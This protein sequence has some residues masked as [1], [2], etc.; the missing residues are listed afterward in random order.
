MAIDAIFRYDPDS[1]KFEENIENEEGENI[2]AMHSEILKNRGVPE[3]AIR[4]IQ[5]ILWTRW[6]ILVGAGLLLLFLA[7]HALAH[8]HLALLDDVESKDICAP[9]GVVS[10]VGIPTLH[11]K[12]GHETR[13]L[14]GEEYEAM[15]DSRQRRGNRS[16]REIYQRE[17]LYERIAVARD[18]IARDILSSLADRG[19]GHVIQRIAGQLHEPGHH[20]ISELPSGIPENDDEIY[21]ERGYVLIWNTRRR[22]VSLAHVFEPDERMNS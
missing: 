11:R 18:D 6:P 4:V 10:Y 14:S 12:W 8:S 7:F 15:S 9:G 5:K 20:E 17:G 21:E 22:Y 2:A 13:V 19:P 3:D 1:T 16:S